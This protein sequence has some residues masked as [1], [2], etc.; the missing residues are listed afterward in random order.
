M[1]RATALI[2]VLT[3]TL[4]W[5]AGAESTKLSGS[6]TSTYQ[7]RPKPIEATFIPTE[8]GAWDL[9]FRFEFNGARHTYRGTG[10]GGLDGAFAGRVTNEG[11]SRTFVFRGSFDGGVFEGIHAEVDRRG[12]E[13]KTGTLVLRG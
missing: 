5:A 11:G 7:D 10:E 1:R 12:R 4:T 13:S 3:L 2:P 8:G 9:E 6:F